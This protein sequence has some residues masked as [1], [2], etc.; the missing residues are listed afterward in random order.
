MTATDLPRDEPSPFLIPRSPNADRSL[1]EVLTPT[2]T[3]EPG[4]FTGLPNPY[5]VMGIY[6]GHF[7]G[8]A[9][10]A[11]LATV[12]ESKLAHSLHAYFL[13][14]GDP[15]VPI[16]YRVS[17]L[18]DGRSSSGRSIHATQDGREVFHMIASFKVAEPGDEH[19]PL[20]PEVPPAA[21]LVAARQ[22]RGEEPWPFPPSQ[23]GWCEIEW[24]S[25]TFRE[26]LPD[27]EPRLRVWARVPGGDAL[28]ARERQVALAFL[29][30]AP[31]VF[32]S[33]LPHGVPFETHFVT[34]LD[35]SVWF[36][37]P[38]DP[39]QWLLFDQSST[40]ATDGRGLN[41]GRMYDPDG[42]LV[43]TVAQESMLR[44]I[45]SGDG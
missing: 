10:S 20:P 2:S 4:T 25:P 1:I 27:R 15:E 29:S 7:L 44:R 14:K 37:R 17:K 33:V 35:H 11:A 13:H 19:Q 5:G 26:Y 40:A 34:S 31:I 16:E 32:N 8:Q 6:G 23:N 43:M 45:P 38:V 24:A 12:D 36:H 9:L 42:A 41:E 3:D 22:A 28:D 21:E 30:D 18:R 39:S